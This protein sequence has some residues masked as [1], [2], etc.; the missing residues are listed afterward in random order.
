MGELPGKLAIVGI[1]I[2]IATILFYNIATLRLAQ[3]QAEAKKLL[4]APEEE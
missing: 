4:E 1:I 2:V 3:A